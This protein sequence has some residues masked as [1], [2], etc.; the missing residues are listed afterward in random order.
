VAQE[1]G[2]VVRTTVSARRQICV[3]FPSQT[4][5]AVISIEP[6]SG[7]GG[8]RTTFTSAASSFEAV[9]AHVRARRLLRA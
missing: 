7:D 3:V 5:G 9:F 8:S 6:G 1:M 4:S 2:I